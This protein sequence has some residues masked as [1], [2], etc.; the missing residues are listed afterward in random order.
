MGHKSSSL[1]VSSKVRV[2][3][4]CYVLEAPRHHEADHNSY[5]HLE[6]DSDVVDGESPCGNTPLGTQDDSDGY[7]TASEVI[8]EESHCGKT[9]LGTPEDLDGD[10]TPLKSDMDKGHLTDGCSPLPAETDDTQCC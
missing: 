9:P 5:H 1:K 7:K 4:V 3:S 2:I 8:E 10:K 6:A